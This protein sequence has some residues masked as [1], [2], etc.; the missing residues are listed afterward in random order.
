MFEWNVLSI[1]VKVG[2]A[3][4][5]ELVQHVTRNCPS[6]KPYIDDI[7][8]SNGKEILNPQKTTI[9]EKQ[10]QK[11]L[12][13]NFQAHAEKLCALFDALA[14]AQLT[15]KPEICHLFKKRVQ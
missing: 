6:S 2:P 7:L 9:A 8:S 4:F 3:A 14:E 13:K 1:G 10:E 12:Q 11:M 5:Q 15:V